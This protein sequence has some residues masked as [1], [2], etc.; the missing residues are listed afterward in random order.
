MNKLGRNTL[1]LG[2]STLLITSAVS[3]SA[4]AATQYETHAEARFLAGQNGLGDVADQ[5]SRAIEGKEATCDA[6]ALKAG[7]CP[8]TAEQSDIQIPVGDLAG[9][10]LGAV[11]NFTE[12]GADGTSRASSGVIGDNGFIDTDYDGPDG[13]VTLSLDNG[14]LTGPVAQALADVQVSLGAV[15]AQASYDAKTNQVERDYNIASADVTA[16]LPILTTIN[17]Q[18]ESALEGYN[19][20]ETLTG[21][22]AITLS[23]LSELFPS[24]LAPVLAAVDLL[25]ENVVDIGVS[26]P[27]IEDLTSSLQDF[28]GGGVKIDV[29]AGTVQ[30]DLVAL[31]DSQDLDINDLPANTDLLQ[32]VL[33]AIAD[34][35]DSIVSDLFDSVIEEIVSKGKVTLTLLPAANLPPV[36][37]SGETL[38]PLLNPVREGLTTLLGTLDTQVLGPLFDTALDDDALGQVAKVT[39]NNHDPDLYTDGS[40]VE[41]SGNVSPLAL[42]DAYS[43]TAVRIQLLGGQAA[44]LRLANAVVG[45]SAAV[46]IDDAAAAAG[47]GTDNDED[48]NGDGT[49]ADGAGDGGQA[50]ADAQAGADAD[51]ISTLPSTGAPN[52]LPFWLLGLGLVLFGGAVLLNER[53]RLIV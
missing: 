20:L 37:L 27:S 9:L 48:A 36:E 32:F 52:L 17:S 22:N 15:S 7:E 34:A 50:A 49:V 35:L 44:D 30:V 23:K 14:R 31:L 29:A 8:V 25:G 12:A 38:R 40:L 4:N 26:F 51:V 13:S 19:L 42:G 41:E 28:S 16:S 39:V 3:F 43:Q 18:L 2:L 53:R 46:Q 33:P 6:A 11:D 5:V 1:A 21:T 10:T 24:Q 45:P 47:D